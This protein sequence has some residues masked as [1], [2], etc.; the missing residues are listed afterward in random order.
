MQPEPARVTGLPASAASPSGQAA[1]TQLD[2][3]LLTGVD[4]V[5]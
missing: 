3:E 1:A 5:A 4:Q 2:M